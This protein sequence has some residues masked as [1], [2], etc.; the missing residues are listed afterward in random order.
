MIAALHAGQPA[1]PSS[2]PSHPCRW[3]I[4]WISR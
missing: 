1:H 2:S 4:W 3:G